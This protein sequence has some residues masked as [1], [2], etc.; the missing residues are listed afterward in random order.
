VERSLGKVQLALD[1]N[2]KI[3]LRVISWRQNVKMT[4][5]M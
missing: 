5:D 2:D 1:V 4:C 3:T